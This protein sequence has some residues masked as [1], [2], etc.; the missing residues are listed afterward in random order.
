MKK[1]IQLAFAC[2]LFA[3]AAISPAFAET[4]KEL[5]SKT[6]YHGIAFARSGSAM[7]LLASHH[8]VFAV[9]KNGNYA[10]V[11]N[12]AGMYRGVKSSD[13]TNEVAIYR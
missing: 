12:S 10:L 7:L 4:L 1:S 5:A 8:G 11:F 6:H 2:S 3:T 9:D 13:G